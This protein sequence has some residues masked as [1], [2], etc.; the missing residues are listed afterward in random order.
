MKATQSLL[1]ASFLAFSA[2]GD[3]AQ[4]QAPARVANDQLRIIVD[5]SSRLWFDG[6]S[7]LH[8]Y[9]AEATDFS[10]A[11]SMQPASEQRAKGPLTLE[12]LATA[13]SIQKVGLSIAVNKLSSGDKGLDENMWK[14]LKAKQHPRI[15]FRMESYQM[16]PTIPDGNFNVKIAGHLSLAGVEKTVEIAGRATRDTQGFRVTGS[17]ELLMTD[18]GIE[19]PTMMLGTIHTDNHIMVGFN[20]LLQLQQPTAFKADLSGIKQ[21]GLSEDHVA[22]R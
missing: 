18:F 6:N 22:K 5:K 1:L 11:L 3:E 4:P 20:I 15:S 19:P 8:K 16:M 2:W 10:T 13:G 7:T 9:K 14:A 12:A 21:Q 17:K